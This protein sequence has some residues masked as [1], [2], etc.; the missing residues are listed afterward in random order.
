MENQSFW[1]GSPKSMFYMGLFLGIAASSTI[2]LALMMGMVWKG[3]ISPGGSAPQQVAQVPSAPLPGA[4]D[5]QPSLPSKPVKAVTADDHVTGAK[6]AK[7][8]LIEYSDFECPFCKRHEP[9]IAQALKDFPDHKVLRLVLVLNQSR[10]SYRKCFLFC[11]PLC[12]FC[13]LIGSLFCKRCT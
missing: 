11:E 8:T 7:V 12:K 4:N 3:K 9:S 5:P 2:A 10:G 1:G 6:N 13:C